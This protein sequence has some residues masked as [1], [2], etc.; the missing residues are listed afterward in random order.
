MAMKLH[1]LINR[2]GYLSKLKKSVCTNFQTLMQISF[3]LRCEQE[4]TYIERSNDFC[5]HIALFSPLPEKRLLL[6]CL[7][8]LCRFPFSLLFLFFFLPF[9]PGALFFFFLSLYLDRKQLKQFNFSSCSSSSP[10]SSLFAH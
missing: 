6:L 8:F 5:S 4:A 9:L 2:T 3:L 10:S 1:N 7:L